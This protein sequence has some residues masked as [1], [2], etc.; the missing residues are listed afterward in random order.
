M[1][2]KGSSDT[3]SD[4][5]AGGGGN[6]SRVQSASLHRYSP[7]GDPLSEEPGEIANINNLDDY[8]ELLYEEVPA[9]IKGQL[10][11]EWLFDVLNFPKKPQK[12]DE[13]LP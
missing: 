1:L 13:F 8:I 9:K 3:G 7:V 11:S 2:Q 5:E 10:I 6:G 4:A 12:F